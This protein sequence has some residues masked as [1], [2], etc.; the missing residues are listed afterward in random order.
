ML[1]PQLIARMPHCAVGP[2]QL[3]PGDCQDVRSNV[4]GEGGVTVSLHHGPTCHCTV[5]GLFSSELLLLL[6]IALHKC[7]IYITCSDENRKS[8]IFP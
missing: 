5:D 7:Y 6:T 3:L 1:A 8:K 2:S 4:T